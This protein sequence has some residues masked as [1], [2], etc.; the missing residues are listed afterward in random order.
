MQFCFVDMLFSWS[1]VIRSLE[2]WRH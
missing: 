2:S 1:V